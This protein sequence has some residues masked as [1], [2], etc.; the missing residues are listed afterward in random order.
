VDVISGDSGGESNDRMFD[1]WGLFGK[2][3]SNIVDFVGESDCGYDCG[4]DC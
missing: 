1:G 2:L 3:E 4:Y